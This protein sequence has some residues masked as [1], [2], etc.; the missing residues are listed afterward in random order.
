MR[1]EHGTTDIKVM[2]HGDEA[3]YFGRGAVAK[4]QL[5]DV[6]TLEFEQHPNEDYMELYDQFNRTGGLIGKEFQLLSTDEKGNNEQL[7]A[8]SKGGVIDV[9]R[10]IAK[11]IRADSFRSTKLPYDQYDIN[12]D[13]YINL[14]AFKRLVVRLWGVPSLIDF[15]VEQTWAQLIDEQRNLPVQM[16]CYNLIEEEPYV[17]PE[18]PA[19]AANDDEDGKDDEALIDDEDDGPPPLEEDDE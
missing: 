1:A 13:K 9:Q 6:D 10:D 3:P 19:E 16:F 17:D 14:A 15:T 2:F 12:D 7:L 8:T 11:Q 18:A 5:K 4:L